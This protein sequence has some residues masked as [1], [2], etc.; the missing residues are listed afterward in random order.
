ML[1]AAEDVNMQQEDLASPNGDMISWDINDIKLPKDVKQIDSF[2]EWPD[3][4][5]KCIYSSD[6]KN[7]QRHLSSWAMRNT[8]NHN[9][10][11]LKKSCLGVVVCSNN[12]STPDGRKMYLRPAICDKARQKQQRKSCPN[13]NG[14]LKLIPCRGHGGYPVTNFWRHEEPFIFFQSKG[15]HDHPRP[16]TKLEAE[17]RRSIQKAHT[18]VPPTSPRFKRSRDIESLTG[19]MQSQD[20]LPLIISEQEELLSQDNF[21]GS[22]RDK[23]SEEHVLDNCLSLTEGYGFGKASYLI[24]HAQV[25]GYDKHMNKCKQ[26]GMRDYDSR[27]P[28]EPVA[29]AY[30]ECREQQSWAKNMEL[31]KNPLADKHHNGATTFLAGLHCETLG[32][33]NAVDFG[34]SNA[35]EIPP[36]VKVGYHP[37][38]SNATMFEEM[39]EGKPHLNYNNC[40]IP[41]SFCQLSPEDPYLIAD[42][43]HHYYQNALPMKGNE[44]HIED[45]RKCVNLDHCNN[46]T[47]FN[48]FPLR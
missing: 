44:W 2:Q 22:F 7:A 40:N 21:R 17:A 47:F 45:E 26:V 28:T 9:S 48:L 19:E 4:Y 30:S 13:C 33:L 29:S 15:A 32:S 43:A 41:A 36:I 10:R 11:I 31:G 38:R 25:M 37:L 14:S 5:V 35:P 6:D 8:N 20:T 34:I 12:C 23:T 1:R 46:E 24:Q 39:C 27:D 42:A 16:E 3:C 18:A